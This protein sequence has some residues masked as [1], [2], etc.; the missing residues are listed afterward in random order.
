V[1]ERKKEIDCRIETENR[2]WF[3]LHAELEGISIPKN[4]IHL[5][6]EWVITTGFVHRY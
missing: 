3:Q 2:Y 1:R 5:S 4:F 6:S